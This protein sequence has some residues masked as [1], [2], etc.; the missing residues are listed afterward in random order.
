MQGFAVDGRKVK[1]LSITLRT[2]GKDIRPGQD[3]RQMPRLIVTFYDQKR[4]I[5]SRGL[6]GSWRGTFD[7][8]VETERV[9][10][11][12]LAREAIIHIGLHGAVGEI[13]FDDLQVRSVPR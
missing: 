7:W 8:Q 11:S 3:V 10:V 6:V 4:A 9:N 12:R 2:R 1:Q 13:S 5:L